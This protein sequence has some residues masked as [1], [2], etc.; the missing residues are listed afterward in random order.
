[1]AKRQRKKATAKRSKAADR[2]QTDDSV[3]VE[4]ILVEDV[5][6]H[7]LVG[8]IHARLVIMEKAGYEI[9]DMSAINDLHNGG[10]KQIIIAGIK[11]P[12]CSA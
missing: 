7:E 4:S 10:T 6:S 1:M 12:D 8:E 9:I 11:R 2:P 5:G 3:R